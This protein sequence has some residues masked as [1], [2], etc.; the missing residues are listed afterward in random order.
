MLGLYKKKAKKKHESD[1]VFLKQVFTQVRKH[2]NFSQ[3]CGWR[4]EQSISEP[5][6]LRLISQITGEQ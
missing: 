4:Q 5:F 2:C 6:R 1:A 3:V